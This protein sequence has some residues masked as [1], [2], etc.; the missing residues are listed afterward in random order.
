[1][2]LPWIFRHFIWTVFANVL[3]SRRGYLLFV[4]ILFWLLLFCFYIFFF[5]CN[6][7]LRALKKQ[8]ACLVFALLLQ[9]SRR[10]VCWLLYCFKEAEGLF[11]VCYN[12]LLDILFCVRSSRWLVCY[13][14]FYFVCRTADDLYNA[15]YFMYGTADVLCAF[16]I[17]ALLLRRRGIKFKNLLFQYFIILF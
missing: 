8:K 13:L 16:D 9:G 12:F 1:M 2:I 6:I 3:K 5:C 7:F 11:A 10:L 15:C 14:L 4:N 17:F